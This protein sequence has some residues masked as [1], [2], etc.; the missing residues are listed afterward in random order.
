MANPHDV[1][2]E[3][4]NRFMYADTWRQQYDLRA[5]ENYKL[6]TG[7]RAALAKE[8]KGRSNLHI[9][10]T[11]ELVDS[12]RARYLRA[13]FAASPVLE[14]IPDPL[15]Y[16]QEG[17]SPEEY[18]QM[19]MSAE[20]SAKFSTHLVDQQLRNTGVYKKFYDWITSVLV[21]PAGILAVGWEDEQKTVRERG[22]VLNRR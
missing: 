15:L 22:N 13:L 6:Y 14:Y 2:A 4:M 16:F 10:K 18:L 19:L 5:V 8:F 12:L 3:L 11:Y 21:F 20:D 7:Y 9:P 1:A 17:V